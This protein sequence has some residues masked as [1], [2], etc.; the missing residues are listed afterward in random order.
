MIA[1]IGICVFFALG[2]TLG[3]AEL[4]SQ[5]NK[6]EESQMMEMD[7]EIPPPTYERQTEV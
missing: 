5:K 2:F 1:F 6:K 4:N 3:I 7:L